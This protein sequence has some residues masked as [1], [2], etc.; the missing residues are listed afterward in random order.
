MLIANGE[1][2]HVHLLIGL[3]PTAALADFVNV[4]KTGTGRRLRN[5]YSDHLGRFYNKPVLWG[6]SYCT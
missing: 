1:A 3:P 2:D 6:R 5:E 4:L